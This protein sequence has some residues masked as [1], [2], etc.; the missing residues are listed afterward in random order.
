M[1]RAPAHHRDPPAPAEEHHEEHVED[2]DAQ[3]HHR[4]KGRHQVPG[5]VAVVHG[6]RPQHQP[7]EEAA[8][9]PHVDP[10]GLQVVPQEP[11]EAAR[12]GRQEKGRP[13]P[14]A[15]HGDARQDQ[16]RHEAD[17]RRQA[18]HDV[19]EV[20]GVRHRQQPQEGQRKGDVGRQEGEL[21]GHRS[22]HQRQDRHHLPCQLHGGPEGPQ[23]VDEAQDHHDGPRQEDPQHVPLERSGQGQREEEREVD[24]DPSQVGDGRALVL[25]LPVGPVHDSEAD[26]RLPQDRRQIVGQHRR[27]EKRERNPDHAAS[28]RP[29]RA[30]RSR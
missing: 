6:Q 10:G 27:G 22:L 16:G 13:V 14:P 1:V 9:V 3:D 8:G 11:Q 12:Q 20:E 28:L 24:G 18:V 7:Q 5:G 23:I 2:G 15:S 19:N 17:P 30:R 26:G 25:Q 29:F 21:D 4:R